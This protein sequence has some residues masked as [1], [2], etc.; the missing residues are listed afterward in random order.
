LRL[1]VAADVLAEAA[2]RADERRRQLSSRCVRGVLVDASTLSAIRTDAFGSSNQN[3][4]P[5]PGGDSKPTRPPWAST[6]RLTVARPKP[7]PG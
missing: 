4:H 6:N 5:D 1:R 3:V 2:R 7:I